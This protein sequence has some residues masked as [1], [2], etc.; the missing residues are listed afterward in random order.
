MVPVEMT[1]EPLDDTHLLRFPGLSRFARLAHAVTIRPW[2]M[3]PH[4]GDQAD[5]AIA[6]RKRICDYLGVPFDRLTAPDQI[7]SHHITTIEDED[8]GAGR[9][10]RDGAVRF[11]D[12]LITDRADTP[13]LQL[14]GDCAL[15]V[16]YDP[17]G[18]AVGAVHAGWRGVVAGAAMQL[19]RRLESEYNC[20]AA[21][22]WIGVAPCAGP[23]RYEIGRDV[24]RIVASLLPDADRFL[25]HRDGRTYFDMKAAIADQLMAA[26]ARAER[27]EIAGACTIT[28]PR[29]YSHRRDGGATGRFALIASL[30]A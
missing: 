2:N 9:T 3:A 21:D 6:R 29:F 23:E 16:A 15:I 30:K 28:D 12:G 19:V 18:H 13:I 11:V 27:I 22:L 1:A 25:P 4:R 20:L 17:V 14:S 10:G 5:R 7:H 8:V 24:A 26:G